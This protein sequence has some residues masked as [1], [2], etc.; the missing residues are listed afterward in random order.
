MGWVQAGAGRWQMDGEDRHVLLHFGTSYI[1]YEIGTVHVYAGPETVE[2]LANP[3]AEVAYVA[4]FL[5]P[6][7]EAATDDELWQALAGDEY[8]K[9]AL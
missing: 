8:T 3:M 5:R 1:E 9:P 4:T 6:D 7:L 2:D